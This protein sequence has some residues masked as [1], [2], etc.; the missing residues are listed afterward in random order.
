VNTNCPLC[1][2][3]LSRLAGI[4]GLAAVRT[5]ARWSPEAGYVGCKGG[6]VLRIKCGLFTRDSLPV[7]SLTS[8]PLIHEESTTIRFITDCPGQHPAMGAAGRERYRQ[9]RQRH[10]RFRRWGCRHWKNP[11]AGE[12]RSTYSSGP[13]PGN[14]P[15]SSLPPSVSRPNAT[16]LPP[17]SRPLRGRTS[18][19]PARRVCSRA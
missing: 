18:L 1:L 15:K 9:L 12:Q 3:L 6:I 17:P 14:L 11:S 13:T 19:K 5:G 8:H 2:R 7:Y 16:N 4:G 10:W